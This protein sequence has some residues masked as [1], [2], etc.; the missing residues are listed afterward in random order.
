[1][2]TQKYLAESSRKRFP[3]LL[4]LGL[5]GTLLFGAFLA[6]VFL[7]DH[8]SPAERWNQEVEP[9]IK[10]MREAEAR[11]D[12]A[13]AIQDCD[14]A[15]R[16]AQDLGSDFSSRIQELKANRRQFLEYQQGEREAD[17]L[18]E[19][20]RKRVEEFRASSPPEPAARYRRARELIRE[21]DDLLRRV[22]GTR[23]RGKVKDDLDFLK[24]VPPPPAIK[25]WREV[26]REIDAAISRNE[27]S[28]AMEQIAAF[29][30]STASPEDK[31]SAEGY[32]F[33]VET[34]AREYF[35]R[36]YPPGKTPEELLQEVGR[37]TLLERVREDLRR[38]K[39]TALETDL[40]AMASRLAR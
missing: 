6:W 25:A 39:G 16:R 7:A 12:W 10:R 34:R 36:R 21:G 11:G 40:E 9:T 24:S 23:A 5:V 33:V 37:G 38:L 27:F 14:E 1:M 35:R 22:A 13:A 31:K 17:A 3:F 15:I 18:A 8:R 4:G 32:R 29:T 30:G 2:S 28:E 26:K 19:G 20:F